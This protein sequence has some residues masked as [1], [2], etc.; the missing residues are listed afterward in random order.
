MDKTQKFF[1]DMEDPEKQEEYQRWVEAE[2]ERLKAEGEELFQ[3]LYWVHRPDDY[4]VWEENQVFLD[5]EWED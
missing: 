4:N 2:E 3:E 1:S 5:R